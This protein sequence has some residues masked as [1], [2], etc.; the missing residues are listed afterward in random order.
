[1][2]RLTLLGTGAMMPTPERALT[3]LALSCRGRTI[4]FDCGEGTQVAMRRHRVS[5]ARVDL[6]ALTH[7]HGDHIFGLPGLLQTIALLGRTE[8]LYFAGPEGIE[9]AL[10]PIFAL[11]G[12]M[13]FELRAVELTKRAA[14]LSDFLP[15][16]QRGSELRAVGTAHRVPSQGYVFHLKRAGR[17][18]PEQAAALGVQKKDWSRL[19]RGERVGRVKPSQVMGP[20]RPGLI[21]A[22]SGDTKPCRALEKAA[23]GADLLIHEATYADDASRAEANRC[24]HSTFADAAGAAVRAGAKRLW[25]THLSQAIEDVPAALEA[26]RAVFP[27]AE[28]PPDGHS[29]RLSFPETD[30]E[31][32]ST[33]AIL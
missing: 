1:M 25:L 21:V 14:D 2:L 3:A 18:L 32:S 17:F 28:C 27:A 7:Y 9:R 12:P 22:F 20:E 4:L 31:S 16:W 6:I 29:L 23:R 13:P 11:A 10:A 5:A 24:G 30:P 26:A 8:P 33:G 19:Q 15:G